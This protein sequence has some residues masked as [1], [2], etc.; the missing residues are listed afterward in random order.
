MACLILPSPEVVEDK[1]SL[2]KREMRGLIFAGI[3]AFIYGLIF[4]YNI[5]PGVPFGG[6]LLDYSQVRYIDKLFGIDSF[7]NSGYVFVITLLFFICG[8]L[9]AIG[10]RKISNNRELCDYLSHSLSTEIKPPAG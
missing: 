1:D 9:Y 4:I 6:N 5:I 7:F 10:A 8:F 3:G 2:T